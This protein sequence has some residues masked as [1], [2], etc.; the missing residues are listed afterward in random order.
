MAIPSR[1]IATPETVVIG[2]SGDLQDNITATGTTQ[3]DAFQ[4]NAVYSIVTTAAS[5]TGVRLMRSEPSAEVFVRNLGANT[6]NVY[7]PV[8]GNFNGGTTNA[9]VTIAANAFQWFIGRDS[10]N[11]TTA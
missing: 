11:W 4:I 1:I 6:L 5:G 8:G 2:I 3:A 7:P 9:P 10:L